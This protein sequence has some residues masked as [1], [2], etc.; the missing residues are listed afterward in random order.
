MI[1]TEKSAI[2]SQDWKYRY[3]L[4]RTW[5]YS[6]D[7]I[8]FIGLNPSTADWNVDDPTIRRC[9][10]YASDWWFWWFYMCNL[11][12]YR[13]TNPSDMKWVRNPFWIENERY[14]EEYINKSQKVLCMWWN[15]WS[16]LSASKNFIKKYPNNLYYLEM[17]NSWEP[18]HLLYSEKDLKPLKM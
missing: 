1:D 4:T 12:A 11:F 10:S 16:Y 18:K 7:M 5:D 14:L 17:N 2:L 9:I 6:K 8:L 13:A 15:H 3:L